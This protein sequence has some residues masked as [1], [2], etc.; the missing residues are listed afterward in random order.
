MTRFLLVAMAV[1]PALYAQFGDGSD[2]A[3]SP[4]GTGATTITFDPA[5]LGLNPAGDNVFKFTTITIPSNVTI[6]MPADVLRNKP[7]IW[8]ATGA[9]NIA[10]TINIAGAAGA[11]MSSVNP[12]QARYPAMPGAGGFPGGIG[13]YLTS[14]ATNGDGYS[15][16]VTTTGNGG[17]GGF[18]YNS[19]QLVPLL[20]GSGGAG[21][22]IGTGPAGGNGGAGGG[23]IR[24]VSAV[25]ITVTGNIYAFG[26]PA[27]GGLQGSYN[28]GNGSG[29]VIHLVA[30][31]ITNSGV[32]NV[33]NGSPIGV[34][35]FSGTNLSIGGSVSTGFVTGPFYNPPLPS[36]VPLVKVVSVNGVAA[37]NDLTG[38]ALAP[39]FTISTMSTVSVNIAAAY[40]P[41]A[42]VV[43]LRL[44]SEQGNDATISCSALAGTLASSTAT[45]TGVTFPQGVT[46]TDIK[47]VW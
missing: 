16:G 43:T 11:T 10:G 3:F 23:A 37:P 36:G 12:G 19:N 1:S 5:V 22:Q 4:T 21:G 17:Q 24:I 42:T 28:G 47:A 6:L 7:V 25:S 40:I 14:A 8:L 29:G 27:G 15:G 31:T 46:I 38:S 34:V 2:G 33:N 32:L 13:A 30:P 9:V 26:G 18:G 41:V 45:C 35:R 44:S 39:D 20:G